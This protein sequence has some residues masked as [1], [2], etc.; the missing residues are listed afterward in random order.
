VVRRGSHDSHGLEQRNQI[1]TAEYELLVRGINFWAP[2]IISILADAPD[3]P[4][5]S[6]LTAS[7]SSQ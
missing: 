1:S 5:W 6:D 2:P 4:R 3:P 7:P